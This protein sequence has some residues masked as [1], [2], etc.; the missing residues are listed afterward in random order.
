MVA[1]D[2]ALRPGDTVNG[3]FRVEDVLGGGHFAT[4]YKVFDNFEDQ[5]WAMKLFRETRSEEKL[6]RE[7]T[8]LRRIHHPNVMQVIW[9]DQTESGQ[10]FMLSELLEGEPLDIFVSKEQF[11]SNAAIARVG[12]ELLDALEAIH[13]NTSR[14]Q[15]L[16]DRTLSDEEAREYLELKSQGFVHRDIKPSN[17]MLT[18]DGLKLVDF[19]IASRVGDRV[20]TITCTPQY[21]PPDIDYASWTPSCDLFAVGVTLYELLVREHPYEDEDPRSGRGPID[22][23]K[24]TSDL[25]RATRAFLLKACAAEDSERFRSASEMKEAWAVCVDELLENTSHEKEA[26]D[27]ETRLHSIVEGGCDVVEVMGGELA[28]VRRME[29]GWPAVF[30]CNRSGDVWASFGSRQNQ[31]GKSSLLDLCVSV[32]NRERLGGGRFQFSEDGVY[33]WALGRRVIEFV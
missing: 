29:A 22:V 14:L 11:L 19:N 1:I 21:F 27:D 33:V 6:K 32:V 12:S 17:L 23:A 9:A 7:I 18:S 8:T 4:V 30:S 3:R 20:E 28:V 26:A 2:R 15:E 10:W 24:Y 13:P 25:G 16:A 5:Y 31:A